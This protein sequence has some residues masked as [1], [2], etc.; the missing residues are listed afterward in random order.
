MYRQKD[1]CRDSWYTAGDYQGFKASVVKSV[2][3]VL[4]SETSKAY[5]EVIERT[6]TEVCD[7]ITG[8][9]EHDPLPTKKKEV[10]YTKELEQAYQ[11]ELGLVGLERYAVRRVSRDKYSRR[12]KI[13]DVV[14][15]AQYHIEVTS[16]DVRLKEAILREFCE[17][18]SAPSRAFAQ[19]IALAQ[20][21]GDN[22]GA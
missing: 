17:R 10:D 18:L 13:V 1:D 6:F 12:I 20:A 22:L 3:K 8:P 9:G 7:G 15:A 21:S 2:K 19:H 16:P 5:C 14:L 11:S 4:K